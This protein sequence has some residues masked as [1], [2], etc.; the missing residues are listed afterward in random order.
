MKRIILYTL[1]ISTL[2][3]TEGFAESFIGNTSMQEP[4]KEQLHCRC[5][6]KKK[7]KGH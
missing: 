4:V 1:F 5:G 6:K 2:C 3:A 7:K